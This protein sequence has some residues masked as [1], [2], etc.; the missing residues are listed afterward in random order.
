MIINKIMQN[1]FIRF[2]NEIV[3]YLM[4]TYIYKSNIINI[5]IIK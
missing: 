5:T 2:I 4:N 1:L 3:R